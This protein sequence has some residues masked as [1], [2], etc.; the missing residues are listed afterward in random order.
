MPD[1]TVADPK[2]R[3]NVGGFFVNED[4]NGL[5]R[6]FQIFSQFGDRKKGRKGGLHD[7][8]S[9]RYRQKKGRLNAP[10]SWLAS[11]DLRVVIMVQ[12]ESHHA[13]IF[14]CAGRLF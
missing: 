1:E 8:D 4:V 11:T 6:Q 9:R 13:E 10:I 2:K 5:W 3:R 12:D 7:N 14:E